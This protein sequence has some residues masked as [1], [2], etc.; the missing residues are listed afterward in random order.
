MRVAAGLMAGG[1]GVF[2]PAQQASRRRSLPVGGVP[3]ALPGGYIPGPQPLNYLQVTALKT[4]KQPSAGHQ[5]TTAVDLVVSEYVFVHICVYGA[6]LGE[7]SRVVTPAVTASV[8]V[9]GRAMPAPVA[10][11]CRKADKI[12]C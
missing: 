5:C 1:T 2:L 7:A 8:F 10:A 9:K 12:A 11:Q 4:S 6:R 3:P